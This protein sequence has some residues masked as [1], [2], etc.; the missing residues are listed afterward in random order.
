MAI[1]TSGSYIDKTSC[2]PKTVRSNLQTVRP[3]HTR[4][5]QP[6]VGQHCLLE[7]KRAKWRS[8]A[9]TGAY[10]VNTV[11]VLELASFELGT[12]HQQQHYRY[13]RN[14]SQLRHKAACMHASGPGRRKRSPDYKRSTEQSTDPISEHAAVDTPASCALCRASSITHWYQ[15]ACCVAT[16]AH[17][18]PCTACRRPHSLCVPHTACLPAY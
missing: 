12:D 7:L 15:R 2:Q 11:Q 18:A 3:G 1:K 17:H 9:A 8:T 4:T 14:T 10:V 5:M 16:A 6:Y 13:K